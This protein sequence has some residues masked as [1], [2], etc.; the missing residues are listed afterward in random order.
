MCEDIGYPWLRIGVPGGVEEVFG[1][2]K[3]ARDERRVNGGPDVAEL[4]G[5]SIPFCDIW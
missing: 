3:G 2:I 1:M 5:G 4:A